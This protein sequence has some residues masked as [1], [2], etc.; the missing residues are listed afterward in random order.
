M[1]DACN[2]SVAA[3]P[4]VCWTRTRRPPMMTRMSR[5]HAMLVIVDSPHG[6]LLGRRYD[7]DRQGP[8]AL[9]LDDGRPMVRPGRDGLCVVE[10]L[11][12]RWRCD[13][14]QLSVEHNGRDLP[15][16]GTFLRDGDTLGLGGLRFRVCI[17]DDLDAAYNEVLLGMAQRPSTLQSI[18]IN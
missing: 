8:S 16:F 6:K 17:T 14:P 15:A 3:R 1:R 18:S 4:V 5:V 11:G 13:H 2:A 7:L 10:K 12:Q 9:W